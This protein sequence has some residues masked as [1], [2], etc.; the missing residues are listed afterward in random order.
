MADA[1]DATRTDQFYQRK[2]L[3]WQVIGLSSA[4]LLLVIAALIFGPGYDPDT[5]QIVWVPVAALSLAAVTAVFVWMLWKRPAIL[6]IDQRGVDLP[7]AFREPLAWSDIHRIRLTRPQTGLYGKRAWIIIDP[8][9]GILAPLRLPVWRRFELKFQK[10][11]GVRIPLHGIDAPSEDIV[12]SFER[13]RPV[14][15][16]DA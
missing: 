16:E 7:I 5:W 4:L 11:H 6:R 3:L 9:P 12:A 14:Q 15:I 2:T 1:D 10:Y 8:S 13:F